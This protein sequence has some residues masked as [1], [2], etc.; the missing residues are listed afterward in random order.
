VVVASEAGVEGATTI[1][2]IT[3]KEMGIG[4][5]RREGAVGLEVP[6]LGMAE[7]YEE[8]LNR[9]ALLKDRL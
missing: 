3:E 6:Q 8:T 1:V 2:T 5:H 7:H 4:V 9:T